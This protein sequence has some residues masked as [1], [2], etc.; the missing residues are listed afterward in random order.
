MQQKDNAART[1]RLTTQSGPPAAAFFRPLCLALVLPLVLLVV[2]FSAVALA[3]KGQKASPAPA[4]DAAQ[5]AKRLAVTP[6][7]FRPP[8][9]FYLVYRLASVSL[10]FIDDGHLLFTFRV[11]SLMKRLPEDPGSDDD[12]LI[13]A[14][15]LEI[16]TG[17][18][19]ARTEWRM[20]DRSRYLWAIGGGH[21]L[22]RQRNK[23][24][25]TDATLHLKPFLEVDGRIERITLSPG[26]K[27]LAISAV[28]AD[29][30]A[31]SNPD[32]SIR[33]GDRQ[34]LLYVVDTATRKLIARIAVEGGGA[35]PILGGGYLEALDSARKTNGWLIH[36]TQFS[37]HKQDN[38]TEVQSSCNPALIPLSESVTLINT[39]TSSS[40]DHRVI[41]A[42]LD[43]RQLWQQ[44]WA[45]R[46]IWPS[47]SFAADGSRF[48]FG[49]LQV[50]HDVGVMDPVNEEDI[51][52]QLVG[53]FDTQSGKLRLVKNATPIISAGQNFA[54]DDNGTRFAILRDAAVEVYDLPRATE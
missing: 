19:L 23:L 9:S 50:S 18:E 32:G 4:P 27:L 31:I 49:S 30:G 24:F 25:L 45:S 14:V 42:S 7:G 2:L 38:V 20:H 26:L 13:R 53:V 3:E 52:S 11:P 29:A 1:A 35:V 22:V 33:I 51:R 28:Q 54:L 47:F 34:S 46:Y 5:P 10:D 21:F 16:S 15:V 48:A 39:C 40:D 37:D 12:Q 43:G 8:N 17:K 36:F 41:A 44:V 6:L